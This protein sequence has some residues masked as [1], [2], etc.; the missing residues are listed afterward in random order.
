MWIAFAAAERTVAA[1]VG[2]F[3]G[4]VLGG[5]LAV[6]LVDTLGEL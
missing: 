2:G 3:I 6:K 4:G 1:L 5:T